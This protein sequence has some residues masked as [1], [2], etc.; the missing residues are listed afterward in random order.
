MSYTP[1]FS[2][3]FVAV[4]SLIMHAHY[5]AALLCP[6]WCVP[7]AVHQMVSH[8]AHTALYHWSPVHP[9]WMFTLKV[10]WALAT[11]SWDQISWHGWLEALPRY[12]MAILFISLCQDLLPFAFGLSDGEPSPFYTCLCEKQPSQQHYCKNVCKNPA[13]MGRVFILVGSVLIKEDI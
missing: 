10:S 5:A 13:V 3:V 7:R 1:R 4:C 8:A 11:G 2:I 9:L 12:H 6:G